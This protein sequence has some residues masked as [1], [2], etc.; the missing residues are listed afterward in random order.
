MIL[1]LFGAFVFE[2]CR[3][4]QDRKEVKEPDKT[5]DQAP[6]PLLKNHNPFLKEIG[7]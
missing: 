2:F 4:L 7:S 6:A 3:C 5:Y 1:M